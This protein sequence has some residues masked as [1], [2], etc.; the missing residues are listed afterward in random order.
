MKKQILIF[1]ITILSA[2]FAVGARRVQSDR[3][4]PATSITYPL[5][6]QIVSGSAVSISATA[7]DNVGVVG[8]QFFLDGSYLG[9]EDKNAPY[10]LSWNSTKAGNGTHTIRARARDAAGN[11]ATSSAVN[12]TVSNQTQ[13][14][15]SWQLTWS[16]EF[17]DT[18]LDISKWITTYPFGYRTHGDELQYYSDN[19]VVVSS[20]T[21]KL[22]AKKERAGGKSYT[23]GIVT[24]YGKFDQAY[25]KFEARM[26]L[27][28]GQGFWPAFWLCA[29]PSQWPPE[30]DVMENLGNDTHTVYLSSH[31]SS[32]YPYGGEPEGGYITQPYYG[33]DFSS[34]FHLFSVE[35]SPSEIVWK[36]DDSEIVST[37]SWVPQAGA[38][39]IDGFYILLNLAVGGNW[40]GS[41]NSNTIFPSQLEIDYVRVYSK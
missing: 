16:D 22:I 18:S 26:K 24:S 4:Q 25:G 20:G 6:G 28:N 37:Q 34:A 32:N 30:I 11:Y 21:L 39:G 10:A 15:S 19:N 23:S 38:Y 41:P 29:Y 31:W 12:F 7:S 36:I 9:S 33:V 27:P 5:A 14:T 13:P 40:P 1:A 17:N 8:V 3:T 2:P 35:W